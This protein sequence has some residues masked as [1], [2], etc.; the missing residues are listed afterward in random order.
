VFKRTNILAVVLSVGFIIICQDAATQEQEPA[1][2]FGKG[3]VVALDIGHN[4]FD[5]PEFRMIL[6]ETLVRDGY[7]VKQL[8]TRFDK[9]DLED[10]DIIISQNPLPNYEPEVLNPLSHL[11]FPTPSAFLKGE[12]EFLYTWISS[13]GSLLLQIE[14]MPMPGAVEELT[15]R[16]NIEIS[17]GFVLDERSL[18]GYDAEA[19][20]VAGSVSFRRHDQSITDHPITNGRTVSERIESIEISCGGAFWLPPKGESLLTLDSSF[21]SLLPNIW[22]EFDDTTPRH[23]MEGWSLA[24]VIRIGSGRIAILGDSWLL[25]SALEEE[26]PGMG[27]AYKESQNTQFTLNVVHWLSGLLDE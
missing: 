6:A 13:G 27:R 9:S 25:R 18:N 22:W 26:D 4:N 16:F 7:I 15:S 19:I 14:H 20:H 12:I 11:P 17:N 5:D 2:P 23:R 8:S 1:Y 21:V 24:G 3:L 10:I